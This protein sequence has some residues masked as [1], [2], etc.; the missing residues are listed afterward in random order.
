MTQFL[1]GVGVGTVIGACAV[2]GAILWACD[3]KVRT[4]FWRDK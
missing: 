3:R 1:F 2:M 4:R